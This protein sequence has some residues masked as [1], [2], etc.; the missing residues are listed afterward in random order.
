M[1]VASTFQQTNQ[2]DPTDPTQVQRIVPAYAPGSMTSLYW[3]RVAPAGTLNGLGAWASL[4][5]WMQIGVVGLASAAVGYFGMR[6]FGDSHIKPALRKVGLA[7]SRA[8]RR[9]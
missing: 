5:S 3:N 8:R 6:K 2:W 1:L 7:G 4:P 9:R